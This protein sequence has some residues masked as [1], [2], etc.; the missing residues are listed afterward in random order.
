MFEAVYLGEYIINIAKKHGLEQSPSIYITYDR[1]LY[2]YA[3]NGET[4][5]VESLL[6]DAVRYYR[7][8]P[9]GDITEAY[10]LYNIGAGFTGSMKYK[11]AVKYYNLA[12]KKIRKNIDNNLLPFIN[13]ELEECEKLL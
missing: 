9:Q 2:N 10:L 6:P 13:Q 11:L 5:K 12:K 4:D 7:L 8:F 3:V 1:L